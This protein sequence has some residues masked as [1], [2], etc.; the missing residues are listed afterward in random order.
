MRGDIKKLSPGER[1][2][3]FVHFFR[4]AHTRYVK[5]KSSE[6]HSVE[7]VGSRTGREWLP[8]KRAKVG[9]IFFARFALL[10]SITLF[11]F[12]QEARR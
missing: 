3:K 2:G 6:K 10:F 12:W 9:K 7:K 1:V 5:S 11:L 8:V 4:E